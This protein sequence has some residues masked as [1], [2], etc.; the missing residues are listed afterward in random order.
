[1]AFL[2]GAHSVLAPASPQ[3]AAIARLA[4]FFIG[5]GAFIW[6]LVLGFL[7]YSVLRPRRLGER[8]EDRRVT[9]R[10]LVLVSVALGLSTLLLLGLGFVDYSTGRHVETAYSKSADTLHVRLIGHQ[11]WWEVQYESPHNPQLLK[12]ANEVHIPVGRPVLLRLE[13]RDVIHSFWAPNLHGKS[14]LIPGYTGE[15]TIQADR[16]GIFRAPCA[17]YCGAQH[18]KMALLVI[19]QPVAEFTTWYANEMGNAVAPA[20]PAAARGRAVFLTAACPFCHT[21]RGTESAGTVAPDLTHLA[22]RQTLAAGTMPNGRGNLGG[23]IVAPQAIKPGNQ[24]PA[25]ALPPKDLAALL[26]YLVTLR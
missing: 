2:Q 17:E 4:E 6:L 15:L 12:T 13:S 26:D 11:W 14:D 22:S 10:Q 23:W 24:M 7:A 18:A 16:P 8:D 25:I 19:A 20:N 9:H 5:F 21:I 3:A 1:M